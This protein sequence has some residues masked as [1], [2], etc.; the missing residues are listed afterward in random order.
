MEEIWKDIYFYNINTN[1]LIDYRGLYQVS[2]FGNIKSLKNKKILKPYKTKKGYLIAHLSNPSKTLRI[3][4]LVAYM[5]IENPNK[6]LQVN[7]IDENKEN[8][9]VNNLEWCNNKYNSNY[10]T[11]NERMAESL[12]G[13]GN[14]KA[15]SVIQYDMDMNFIKKWDT[16]TQAGKGLKINISSICMC[17]QGKIECAGNFKWKYERDVIDNECK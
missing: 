6:Y 2:N 7:H 8:N 12:V 3:H 17:C 1:E 9:H 16:M 5:F 10:G 13:K 4:T 11:R 14:P 15:T